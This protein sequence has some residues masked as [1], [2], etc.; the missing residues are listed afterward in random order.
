MPRWERVRLNRATGI[1]AGAVAIEVAA[2]VRAW[3]AGATSVLGPVSGRACEA[4][5]GTAVPRACLAHRQ[6]R[7]NLRMLCVVH[8]SAHSACTF[9]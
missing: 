7:Y 4:S 5:V 6:R 8:T 1:C 2:S 3:R 9:A